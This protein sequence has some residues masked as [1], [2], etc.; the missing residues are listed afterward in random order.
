MRGAEVCGAMVYALVVLLVLASIAGTVLIWGAMVE[1]KLPGRSPPDVT[2]RDDGNR[3][4]SVVSGTATAA[5][6]R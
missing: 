6:P 4:N 3:Q 2:Q 1:K 5:T